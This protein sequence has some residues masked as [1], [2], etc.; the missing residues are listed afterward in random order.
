MPYHVALD[1]AAGGAPPGRRHRHDP[2]RHRAG[3]RRSG[4]AT[5]HPHGRP[6]RSGRPAP[7]S[8]GCCPSEERVLRAA[9]PDLPPFDLEALY[10]RALAWGEAARRPHRRHDQPR[11][12]RPGAR[13][14]RPARGR[15]G[16]AARPRPRHLPLRHVQQPHR[17]RRLHR[18]RRRAAPDRP[19][20]RRHEGL[21]DARRAGPVPDGARR[22]DRRHLLEKGREFGTTTGRQRRCGWFDA[23]PLRYAVRST[24][25]AA[26]CSTSSTSCPACPRSSSASATRSTARSSTAGRCRWPSWSAPSRSTRRSRAGT[27]ELSH[28]AAARRP[29]G[30]GAR[31][32]GRARGAGRRAHHARQRRPRADPDDRPRPRPGR[33][34]PVVVSAVA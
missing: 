12:G 1:G 19:G 27:Q 9:L 18:R 2:A 33:A 3:L 22:R 4:V 23:V 5:G 10:E 16:H 14:A 6:A 32:R 24:A 8:R 28:A 25:S 21:L 30:R 29:A 20:H 15:P 17:G 31:L 26:S 13:R 11:P 7:R 34:R